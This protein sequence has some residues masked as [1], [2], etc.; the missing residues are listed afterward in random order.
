MTC[1]GASDRLSFLE[2]AFSILRFRSRGLVSFRRFIVMSLW[3]GQ[4][5]QEAR[6]EV[7]DTQP[8]RAFHG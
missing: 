8:M 2:N 5:A 6:D 4:G 3:P 1:M 7:A